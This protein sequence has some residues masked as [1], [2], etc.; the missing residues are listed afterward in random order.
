M[1]R[2]EKKTEI[3]ND[4]LNIN[5]DC[6]ATY[7]TYISEFRDR[8]DAQVVVQ[9]LD[10]VC[11]DC[12]AE[13]HMRV[14]PTYGDPADAVDLKGVIYRSWM[15]DDDVYF[16]RRTPGVF[17]SCEQ[18]INSIKKAYEQ[19]LKASEELSGDIRDLLYG[20]LKR[21]ADAF[22]LINEYKSRVSVSS[23]LV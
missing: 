20:Q 1:K 17:T 11:R 19:A 18:K 3:L 9:Q 14:D 22:D 5:R 6:S 10:G 15:Q 21:V 8:P 12:I 16:A 7:R 13:L 2:F 4:L 23:T